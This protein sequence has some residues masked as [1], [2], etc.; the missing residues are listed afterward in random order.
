VFERFLY[1]STFSFLTLSPCDFFVH[2]NKLRRSL[3]S[4]SFSRHFY[5]LMKAIIIAQLV[6]YVNA[7]WRTSTYVKMPQKL[8]QWCCVYARQ[9]IR[10][11]RRVN[12]AVK[13][14]A[15]N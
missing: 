2:S 3:L 14:N 10:P 15:L 6:H 7:G 4:I 5:A 8:C 12:S 13:S 1:F 9:R 11:I